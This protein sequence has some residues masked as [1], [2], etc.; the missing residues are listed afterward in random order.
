MLCSISFRD[1]MDSVLGS[2]SGGCKFELH[3]R[4]LRC[5]PSNVET[6]VLVGHAAY[7]SG[8]RQIN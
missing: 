6:N 8:E 5:P 3:E 2:G 1:Q 4:S 7:P